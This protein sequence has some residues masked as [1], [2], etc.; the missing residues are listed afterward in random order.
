MNDICTKAGRKCTAIA[1]EFLDDRMTKSY[2][3]DYVKGTGNQRPK[4]WS[5]HLYRAGIRQTLA[6]FRAY[7]DWTHAL[8]G[9]DPSIWLTEQGGFVFRKKT[10]ELRDESEAAADVS[11]LLDIPSMPAAPNK[12]WNRGKRIKKFYYYEFKGQSP[13]NQDS[14]LVRPDGSTRCE[15]TDNGGPGLY[16]RYRRRSNPNSMNPCK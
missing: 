10:Q 1:G 4:I 14:G 11:Y 15:N 16:V 2:F 9:S 6:G 8:S 13:P 12:P 7:L 5:I 3:D